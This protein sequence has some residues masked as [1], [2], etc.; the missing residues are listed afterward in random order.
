MV[1]F[2]IIL[3]SREITDDIR[4][5]KSQFIACMKSIF[6]EGREKMDRENH[7]H[8]YM[9]YGDAINRI[10]KSETNYQMYSREY[11]KLLKLKREDYR[12][13]RCAEFINNIVSKVVE[14]YINNE[15]TKPS[16][17]RS[18]TVKYK[19]WD[20]PSGNIVSFFDNGEIFET[21]LG[22]LYDTFVSHNDDINHIN[23]IE[24]VVEN[25]IYF[26]LQN[27][28]SG[29]Y[30]NFVFDAEYT[31]RYKGARDKIDAAIT[32]YYASK[33]SGSYVGD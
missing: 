24:F 13:Q 4:A 10:I 16:V 25:D 27:K 11:Q 12:K 31:A 7:N 14:K 17:L 32:E 2:P 15:S 21:Y 5:T 28:Y 18:V 19:P 6:K 30:I 22:K 3:S 8:F 1:E 26:P 33:P 9:N 20:Y 29:A 23:V